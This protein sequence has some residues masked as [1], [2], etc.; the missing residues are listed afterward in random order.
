ME[1]LLGLA[2]KGLGWTLFVLA[3]LV[4]IY[5][6]RKSGELQDKID[7]LLEKR[8]NDWQ[9]V[10]NTTND[11]AKATQKSQEAMS[12]VINGI[13]KTLGILLDREKKI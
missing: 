12:V 2:E 13:D 5:Q 11:L 8:V 3:C 6:Y 10:L 4:V 9:T 7:D 1:L